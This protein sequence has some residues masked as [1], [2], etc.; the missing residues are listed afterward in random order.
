MK[1]LYI[2]WPN[3]NS[4]ARSCKDISEII[5]G[6]QKEQYGTYI[7]TFEQYLYHAYFGTILGITQ[8]NPYVPQLIHNTAACLKFV[9]IVR[10]LCMLSIMHILTIDPPCT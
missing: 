1:G 2:E 9:A 3:T 5:L 7:K 10:S 6:P 4:V 8:L